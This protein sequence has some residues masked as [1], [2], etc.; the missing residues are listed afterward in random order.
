MNVGMRLR[1][2]RYYDCN[3]CR[4]W[5]AFL[6]RWCGTEL[7]GYGMVVTKKGG[8]AAENFPVVYA[9]IHKNVKKTNWNLS[10]MF[11]VSKLY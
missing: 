1:I 2:D 10:S 7:V 6:I 5:G 11:R 9:A 3:C 4:E 8:T